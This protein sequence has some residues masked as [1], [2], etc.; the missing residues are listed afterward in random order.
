MRPS[1]KT[2]AGEQRLPLAPVASAAE[3]ARVHVEAL[4]LLSRELG[5]EI[6]VP[7]VDYARGRQAELERICR[8]DAMWVRADSLEPSSEA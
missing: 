3:Q 7:S 6:I 4:D 2:D 8:R 5:A 1:A